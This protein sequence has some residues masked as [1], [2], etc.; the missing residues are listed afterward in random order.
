RRQ[1]MKF[2]ALMASTLSLPPTM[3]PRIAE[4]LE[5]HSRQSVIWLSFQECTGCTEAMLRA[6]NI[7]LE[8]GESLTLENL[9]FN[10][11][12]LDYHHT[13]QAAAGAA[14]EYARMI[15]AQQEEY[16]LVVEG[17]IPLAHPGYSTIAGLSNVDLLQQM[18]QGAQAIIAVGNCAAFGGIGGALPNPTGAVA[19]EQRLTDKPL[20][21]LPGCPPVPTVLSAT[22]VHL[23]TFAT[24]PELDRYRRPQ[25]FF[26]DSVHTHCSRKD[27]F[28][29]SLFAEHFDDEGAKAGWC[30]YKLGCKGPVTYNA[31]SRH[32]WNGA[33]SF[34]MQSGHGCLGCSEPNFW[35]KRSIYSSLFAS[36]SARTLPTLGQGVGMNAQGQTVTVTTEFKG[37]A[38]VNAGQFYQ[39]LTLS[40][41]QS[42]EI[43]GQIIADPT[44]IGQSVELVVFAAYTPLGAPLVTPPLYFMLAKPTQILPWNQDV[45]ELTALDSFTL[46][47]TQTQRLYQGQ[48]LASGQLHISF[49]YRLP[50]GTV[51]TTAHSI[52]ILIT[53]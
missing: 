23:I 45:V 40:L 1:F 33:T 26:G 12:S 44:H 3:I 2:C 5:H 41:A 13:L 7:I 49:G 9:I 47:A 36:P 29:Q 52:D 34:P 25:S 8:A 4:A 46:A 30:L 27:F 24:L 50:S 53:E 28:N 38:T 32:K 35:D 17:S 11:I 43:Q 20:V 48:L 51:V 22:L 37:G 42:I 31:C 14:A 15:A 21:Q 19:V 39:Q 10:F 6:D 18:A 16:I